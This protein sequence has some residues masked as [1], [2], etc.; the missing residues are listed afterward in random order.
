MKDQKLTLIARLI[1]AALL[2]TLLFIC[3]DGR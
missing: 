3:A 2:A 1:P